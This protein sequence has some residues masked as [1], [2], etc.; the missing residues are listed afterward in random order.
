LT[1]LQAREFIFNVLRRSYEQEISSNQQH[2]RHL[3][4]AVA[5]D[6]QGEDKSINQ[7]TDQATEQLF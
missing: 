7:P 2:H 4:Q 3:D 5:A 1:G 6:Q